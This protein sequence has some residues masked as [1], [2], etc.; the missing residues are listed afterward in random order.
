MLCS[1]TSQQPTTRFTID[2]FSM[3]SC[4]ERRLLELGYTAEDLVAYNDTL[5]KQYLM[6]CGF[7]KKT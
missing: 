5:A 3:R 2:A 4:S 6:L 1:S 7:D